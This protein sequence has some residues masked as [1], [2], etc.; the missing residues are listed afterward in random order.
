[1]GNNIQDEI[2]EVNEVEVPPSDN[3]SNL[4]KTPNSVLKYRPL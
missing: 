1:M 2:N 3:R 4:S